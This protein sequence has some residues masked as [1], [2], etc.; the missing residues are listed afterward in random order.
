M[1]FSEVVQT[2]LSY[3][4]K[5]FILSTL[6]PPFIFRYSDFMQTLTHT[7]IRVSDRALRKGVVLLDIEEYRK[8]QMQSVPE[9]YLTGK[10]AE[11]ADRLVEEGMREYREGKAIKLNSLKDLR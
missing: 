11:E 8:L 1:I 2:P 4:H 5:A 9:I 3:N 10:A 7:T 6:S